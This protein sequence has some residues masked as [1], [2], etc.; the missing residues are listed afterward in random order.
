[1]G[2]LDKKKGVKNVVVS[3]AFRL[4]LLVGAMVTRRFLIDYAGNI[5]NGL[6]SL[7][8]SILGFLAVAELGVGTAITFCMYKPIVDGDEEKVAALYGLFKKLYLIIGGVILLA[9]CAVMPFLRFLVKDYENVN[10]S[11]YLSFGIMLVSVVATYLFSAKISLINAYKNNYVATA[12]TSSGLL[13]QYVL[14]IVVLIL[15]GSFYWYLFCRIVAVAAQ[16]AATELVCRKGYKNVISIKSRVDEETKKE[17]EKNVKAMFMHKIGDV[18]VNTVDSILISIFFGVAVLGT[19]TNYVTIM[20]ALVG[21]INLFFSPLTSVIGHL[22]CKGSSNE[23][24]KYLNFFHTFNFV[25]GLIFLL[26]YYAIIDDL[27]T[28]VYGETLKM[29]RGT[30]F[31]VTLSYY[32]QFQ[33][34]AVLLFKDSTG[35][36]YYDRYKPIVEGVANLILSILFAQFWGVT[37]IIFATIIT[38]LFICHIVEP[39]VLYKYALARPAKNYYI[40]N[41][42]C[43]AVFTG[44]L[45]LLDFCLLSFDGVWKELI[46]NGFISVGISLVICTAF[47]LI[48]KDFRHYLARGIEKL[49]NRTKKPEQYN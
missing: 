12:I 31:V 5:L 14:Q 20:T 34:R 15:T 46:V 11:L 16:W 26:G 38:N 47:A 27:V 7:Y 13:L 25:L 42:V 32:I 4:L 18:L 41:Y 35:T 10:V 1:M 24:E 28:L 33:R 9:G 8:T 2:N 17:V 3:I 23:L 30:T 48:D 45:F 40:K 37:G 44:A 21:T 49:K 29:D 22:Y 19:Y 36:F 6:D 43:I 39:H